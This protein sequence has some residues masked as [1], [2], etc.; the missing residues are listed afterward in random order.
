MPRMNANTPKTDGLS[1]EDWS[2]AMGERWLAHLDQFESMIAPAGEAL[3]AHAGFSAG[4]RVVDIGCGGGASS[5]VIA[6]SVGP[7]GSV[8][9]LDLSPRLV[10]EAVRRAQLAGLDNLQ[11][12]AGD[13]TT[14]QPSGAPFDRL[15]SRFGT[16]FFAD[17]PQAFRNL[18][19]LVRPGGR[20][21]LLVWAPAKENEWVSKLMGILRSHVEVPQPPPGTPGP[22]SLDDP[23][24][25]R[26]L[27]EGA[28]FSQVAF[29]R[30]NGVQ[31]VGGAGAD[32]ARAARFV[33]DG[34]SF[35]ALLA[36]Q[37]AAVRQAAEAE[38][39]ALLAAHHTPRGV[40]MGASTWLV[41]ARR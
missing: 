38:I 8:L 9:G 28:G 21:D 25:L 34:M 33:F 1:G 31:R 30:W 14:A 12:L 32:P 4:E 6:R 37:S 15:L 19:S 2:G 22:F 24:L 18:G 26:G 23:A 35:G 7:Q 29:T 16:M 10:E 11:F 41:T 27:L 20:V 36:E 17:P 40:E 3:L 13:A 39:L 5:Q